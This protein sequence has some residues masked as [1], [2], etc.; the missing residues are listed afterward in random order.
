MGNNL[1]PCWPLFRFWKGDLVKCY[2]MICCIRVFFDFF[3]VL[4]PSGRHLGPMLAPLGAIWARFSRFLEPFWLHVVAKLAL[5]WGIWAQKP[6]LVGL[7]GLREVSQE[8]NPLRL[9][10]RNARSDPPPNRGRR[11]ESFDPSL[12]VLPS[13]SK[14]KFLT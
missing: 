11:A 7:V 9:A 14:A 8:T 12:L 13:P 3:A 5:S 2:A 1:G 4:T 6:A 10:W